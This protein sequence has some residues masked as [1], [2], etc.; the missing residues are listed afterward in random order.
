MS[1]IIV[2]LLEMDWNTIQ[3]LIEV[4]VSLLLW[5]LGKKYQ[6]LAIMKA[7]SFKRKRHECDVSVATHNSVVIGNE[8]DVIISKEGGAF[9]RLTEL[10]NSFGIKA[11]VLT[12]NM[13]AKFDEIHIG[14]PVSNRY[15]N[16]Y[17][18]RYLTS[19]IKWLVTQSHAELYKMD[20]NLMDSSFMRIT[21]DIEGFEVGGKVYR[22]VKD[23]EGWAFIIRMNISDDSAPKTV[24]LLFGCGTNGTIGAVQYF[25]KNYTH[26]MLRYFWK[27]NYI[28]MF[29]VD[30]N[31]NKIGRIIWLDTDYY[32]EETLKKLKHKEVKQM[33]LI[34]EKLSVKE[35][36]KLI[37]RLSFFDTMRNNLLSFSFTA[38]LTALGAMLVIK[39]NFVSTILCLVPFFLIIP[40]AA[41]ISYYRLASAHINAFLKVYAPKKMRFEIG[42]ADVPERMCKH[43]SLIAW[44]V[45]H[46]MLILGLAC[47]LAFGLRYMQSVKIWYW[48]NYMVLLVP[49]IPVII[50]FLLTNATYDYA[51]LTEKF[52]REWEN[53]ASQK[54]EH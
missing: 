51:L 27:K 21:D 39:N 3:T 23:K 41:R 11:N 13:T 16:Q 50:I 2:K 4:A 1:K 42:C 12:A 17:F 54:V 46:E 18:G 49:V 40:F 20:E 8:T 10:L 47:W 28:G 53:S 44:L 52:Q 35:Y 6:K 43:Y 33:P 25:V 31:G 15:T 29:K 45:N 19:R 22:Y 32:I 36:D 26:I 7:L 48:W 38:V 37:E 9:Y 30:K 34:I 14:G 24:H 5:F